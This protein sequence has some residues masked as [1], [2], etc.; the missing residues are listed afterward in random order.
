MVS[1]R[2]KHGT[3]KGKMPPEQQ[4]TGKTPFANGAIAHRMAVKL[5]RKKLGGVDVYRCPHCGKF[6][7][8]GSFK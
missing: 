1:K 8:G 2:V 5:T 4:C 7:I 3:L 6:H